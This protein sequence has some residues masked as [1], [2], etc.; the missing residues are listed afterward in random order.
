MQY[1]GKLM[2]GADEEA[3]REAVAAATLGSAQETLALHEIERWRAEL[4]ADDEAL[5]AG[6]WPTPTPTASN[7]AAWCAPPA[8]TPPAWHPKRASRELSRAVP[9]HQTRVACP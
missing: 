6:C 8:A 7:C 1:V 2:R 9:V 3:L 4:I 5:T